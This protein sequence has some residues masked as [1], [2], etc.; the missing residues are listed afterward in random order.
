MKPAKILAGVET[1]EPAFNQARSFAAIES[2][3]LSARVNAASD[4]HLA[5]RIASDQPAVKWLAEQVRKAD[6]RGKVA[7]RLL[8][9]SQ[10]MTDFRYENPRDVALLV[11]TLV[12]SQYAPS[13]TALAV[14]AV[15]RAPSLWWASKLVTQLMRTRRTASGSIGSH[16][17]AAQVR[18]DAGD[19][20]LLAQPPSDLAIAVV[21]LVANA[22]P[23]S[24]SE[25][26]SGASAALN[27]RNT[28]AAP[29]LVRVA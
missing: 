27:R 16:V 23:T 2:A 1:R 18:T 15:A 20:I 12:L 28:G 21:D 22:R 9:L 5:L 3:E 17:E 7:S 10:E 19:K 4:L 26:G 8:E 6:A 29:R 24:T 13:L 25:T 11:Y 14:N